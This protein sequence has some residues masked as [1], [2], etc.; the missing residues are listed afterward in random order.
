MIARFAHGQA[1]ATTSRYRPG[2]TGYPSRPS[3]VIRV[4]M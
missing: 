3:A 1:R 4:P 2:S